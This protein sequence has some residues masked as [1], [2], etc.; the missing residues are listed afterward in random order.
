MC[1]LCKYHVTGSQL[2]LSV[3]YF[4]CVNI[5]HHWFGMFRLKFYQLISS[6]IANPAV[7]IFG[8]RRH[9]CDIQL[10]G[11]LYGFTRDM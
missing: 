8:D 1:T 10:C 9:D 3:Q 4:M 2:C 7:S 5:M 6:V 11:Y